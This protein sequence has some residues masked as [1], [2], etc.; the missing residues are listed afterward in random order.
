MMLRHIRQDVDEEDEDY[1]GRAVINGESSVNTTAI[2]RA[3]VKWSTEEKSIAINALNSLEN[4]EVP[5]R[6]R[7]ELVSRELE[8]KGY[9]RTI[10]ACEIKLRKRPKSLFEG[11]PLAV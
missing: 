7:A 9:L 10:A 6:Q 2:N 11:K 4:K 1:D 8:K 3:G 5:K